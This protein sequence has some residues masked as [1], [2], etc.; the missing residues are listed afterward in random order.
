MKQI[1]CYLGIDC[2]GTTIKAGLYDEKCAEL[3]SARENLNFISPRPGYG[4]RDLYELSGQCAAVIKKAL[5]KADLDPQFIKGIAITAQG[6]G[7]Y[8]IGKDG[9]PLGNGI[10]SA[11]RRAIEVV[12]S[13]QEQQIPQTIYPKTRQTLWTGHPVSILRY[14]K[15][16]D[17]ARYDAIDTVFMAHDYLR[18]FLT[19]E[20]GVEITNISE[21]NLYNMKEGSFDEELAKILGI[22]ESLEKMPKIVGSTELCGKVTQDAAAKTGLKAGTPVFGGIFDVVGMAIS[23]GL[24]DDKAINCAMGTWAVAT[25]FTDKL[26]DDPL[27]FVYGRH[28]KEGTYIIHEASPTSSGNL[29]W[30]CDTLGENDFNKINSEIK[31]LKK[32][33]TDLYFIPF[34]YGTNASL[35]ATAGFYGLQS[36]HTKADL[37]QA[38]FEGVVFSHIKHLNSI[39]RKFKDADK[40]IITGGS[41]NSAEWMQIFADA[42]GLPVYMP[43]IEENGC[44]AA[45]M[46][47]QVGSGLY[48]SLKEAYSK[49]DFEV[50]TITPDPKAF[51]VYQEKLSRYQILVECLGNFHK[52]AGKRQYQGV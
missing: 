17:R 21:S 7:V 47:A 49:A 51:D 34:L 16:A 48:P 23:C 2:G 12:R 6:K 27:P 30:V 33:G 35:D 18:Y 14:L 5:E 15:D 52:L 36:I 44:L 38:C 29:E 25:A 46:V 11:D 40:L 19:G 41:T 3:G 22:E 42:A 9:L 50:K 10:L 37:F 26:E 31:A 39:R 32:G 28:V 8:P 43:Q 20:K 1:P 45:A 13:W 4:E 24:Y